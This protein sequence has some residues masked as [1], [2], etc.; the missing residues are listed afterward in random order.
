MVNFG[1]FHKDASEPNASL[2]PIEHIPDSSIIGLTPTIEAID[3]KII[4][5]ERA[6]HELYKRLDKKPGSILKCCV[7]SGLPTKTVIYQVQGAK[8]VQRYCDACCE[9][10]FAR[11]EKK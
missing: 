10:Q 1:K 8:V 2:A 6:K 11:T 7:C 3:P 5:Q 4:E 9:K